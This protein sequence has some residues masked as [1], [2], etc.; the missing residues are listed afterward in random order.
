MRDVA[1]WAG[2]G[3]G[4]LYRHFPTREALLEA[5]LRNSFDELRDYADAL[6]TGDE[7]G[8]ALLSLLTRLATGSTAYRGLSE[9]VMA[10]LR[11]EGS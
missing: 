1:R 7:P 10:A 9:S 4:T 2:V 5:L 6:L 11:D 8:E 3:I